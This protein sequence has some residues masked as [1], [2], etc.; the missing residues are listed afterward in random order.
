MAFVLIGTECVSLSFLGNKYIIAY[1]LSLSLEPMKNVTT[2]DKKLPPKV[3]LLYWY[4][5]GSVYRKNQT[6]HGDTGYDTGCHRLVWVYFPIL[7]KRA[8]LKQDT[9][10]RERI[11][12]KL[13][14]MKILQ[15]LTE[16]CTFRPLTYL[17]DK[18]LVTRESL[19]NCSMTD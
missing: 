11:I 16:Y 4:W 18:L 1:K 17:G 3:D 2:M 14:P 6:G 12:C 9:T 8:C 7:H 10:K 13:T 15:I 5:C 19:H